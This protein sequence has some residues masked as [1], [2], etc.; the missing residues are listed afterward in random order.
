MKKLAL[1]LALLPLA[2]AGQAAQVEDTVATANGKAILLSEYK[3]ELGNVLDQYRHNAPQILEDPEKL[4]RIKKQV[5]DDMVDKVLLQQEAEK[6]KIKVF[7]RELEGGVKEV[8]ER[9]RHEDD[10]KTLS[11]EELDAAFSAELKKQG[12]GYS[13]FEERIKRDLAIRKFVNETLRPQVKAPEDKDVQAFYEKVKFVVNG[14]TA[15]LKDL[16]EQEAGELMTLGRQLHDLLSARVRARHILIRV[17][18]DAKASERNEALKKIQGLRK[19][20]EGGGDFD[21]L[22]RK[23]SQDPDS[24][25]RGGDLGYLVSGMTVPEFEK[26]AFALG[27]G[28]L[29]DVVE[30][31][32]GYHLIRVDEKRAARKLVYDEVKDDLGQFLFGQRL[33]RKL[34]AKVKE[35]RGA[36]TVETFPPKD[37]AALGIEKPEQKAQA[38]STPLSTGPAPKTK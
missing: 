29:S 33:Q 6:K 23:N 24:A 10:G 8:K 36:A 1:L 13:Q 19:Q 17:A 21:E 2:A 31:P 28:D 5:L 34:E 14:D 11:D 35:L 9:F 25:A 22:A 27:V 26:A 20:I 12:L 3:K 30:S 16:S 32:F 18:R 7:S 4:E 38:A 15:P 37:D